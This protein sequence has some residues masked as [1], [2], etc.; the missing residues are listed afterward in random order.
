MSWLVVY[1]RFLDRRMIDSQT[2]SEAQ[3]RADAGRV[4]PT[5]PKKS[6]GDYY[7]TTMSYL[8][9]AFVGMAMR[10]YYQN[11]ITEAQLAEHLGVP[12]KNISGIEDRFLRAQA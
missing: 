4:R 1:R 12:P 3:A 11:R 8:G 10:E 9:K 6:G 5:E 7:N 2:Y